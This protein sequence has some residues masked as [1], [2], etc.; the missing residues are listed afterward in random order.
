MPEGQYR[1]QAA[2]GRTN[3]VIALF[4]ELS[5]LDDCTPPPARA[6][7]SLFP[8]RHLQTA[9]GVRTR[10]HGRSR[11]QSRYG[12]RRDQSETL[13]LGQYHWQSHGGTRDAR[14]RCRHHRTRNPASTRNPANIRSRGHR[15]KP[16]ADSHSSDRS[17]CLKCRHKVWHAAAPL[18]AVSRAA[19]SADHRREPRGL[20]QR[21]GW[22]RAAQ[23]TQV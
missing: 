17:P 20:P 14:G 15:H 11:G 4:L 19:L 8:V 13:A 5:F 2:L 18:M 7:G 23:S 6:V 9:I 10:Q 3:L 1:G 21:K 22:N 12:R 16:V